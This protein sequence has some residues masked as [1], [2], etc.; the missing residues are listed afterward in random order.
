LVVEKLDSYDEINNKILL[1]KIQDKENIMSKF[2]LNQEVRIIAGD[3]DVVGL[4]ATILEVLPNNQ[5]IIDAGKWAS[6]FSIYEDEL[7]ECVKKESVRNHPIVENSIILKS[8]SYKVGHWP[9]YP[10]DT[11]IVFDYLESR[12]G[13]LFKNTPFY[14]LQAIIIKHLVGKVVTREGIEEAAEL[15]KL[16][17]GDETVF[18]RKGWEY[19]LNNWG[20]KLPVR[21][22]AV[23]EGT[24][25]G[26]SNVLMTVENTDEKCYWLPNYLETILS[27]VWYPCT[28]AALSRRVKEIEKQYLEE[29]SGNVGGLDFMLHD[30]GFRG[31][32][33]LESAGFGGSAHLI[34]FKGTDTLAAMTFARDFYK[35]DLN[36]LAFSVRATEHSI[37]TALGDTG[38]I[39]VME[40][41]LMNFPKGILSVVSDSYDIENFVNNIVGKQFKEQILEREGI[42]VVRPDSVRGPNDTPEEQMVWIATSLWNNFG[43]TTNSKGYAV[44]NPKIRM[45]WGDGI[46]IVGIEKILKALKE[47]GFSAENVATFGMGGGL[48]QKVNRDTQRFAFKCSAQMRDNMWQ[49]IWKKPKDVSKASKRGRLKLVKSENGGFKT[50]NIDDEGKDVLE[51]VFENGELVKFQTFEEIR[52][53]AKLL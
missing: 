1:T 22:R 17:F 11:Q 4:P 30:F 23:P 51:T 16:H 10:H 3:R 15:C 43:G 36:K 41:L 49:D 7:E 24:V 33:S 29:T 21:I 5:Y 48:L 25:V 18:N 6:P 52:E 28:V 46:D 53:R 32:S 19:I 31:V 2:K 38:E 44:I 26:E 14:G 34:N 39:K 50:V 27:Q 45:L 37:M 20:G 12:A 40:D 8:D 47:A 13:A 9:M 42:F 35:A